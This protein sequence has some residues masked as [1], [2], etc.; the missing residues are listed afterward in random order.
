M[1][2]KLQD[3]GLIQWLPIE[4]SNSDE[5]IDRYGIRIPVI[6]EQGTEKEAGW[7]FDFEQLHDWVRM[8]SIIR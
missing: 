4:I 1:L 5:L 3:E 7:P 2:N 6:K 8:G